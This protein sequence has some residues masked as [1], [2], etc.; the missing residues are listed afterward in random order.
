M[1]A[2]DKGTY[3]WRKASVIGEPKD[4]SGDGWSFLLDGTGEG[5][6]TGPPGEPGDSSYKTCKDMNLFDG[7]EVEIEV[8][9]KAEPEKQVRG[10]RRP[11]G[12]GHPALAA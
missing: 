6:G 12:G 1:A 5:I 9:L 8:N 3:E 7:E 4:G 11:M 2:N 10:V